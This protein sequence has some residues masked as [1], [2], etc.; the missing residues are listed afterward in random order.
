M[1]TALTKATNADRLY[2]ADNP[3]RSHFAKSL[4]EAFRAVWQVVESITLQVEESELLFGDETVYQ[5]ENRADSL[6]F[7]FWRSGIREVSFLEGFEDDGLMT[8]RKLLRQARSPGSGDFDLVSGLWESDFRLMQYKIVDLLGDVPIPE[9]GD[10]GLADL[11]TVASV[12]LSEADPFDNGEGRLDHGPT[13]VNWGDFNPTLYALDDAEINRL[14]VELK[15][16]V[17]RDLRGDVLSALFDRLEEDGPPGRGEEILEIIRSMLPHLLSRSRLDHVVNVLDELTNLLDTEGVLTDSET[18]LADS[19]LEEMG[20]PAALEELVRSLREGFVAPD[21]VV[22]GKLF[23][24]LR[25]EAIDTLL[26]L[27]RRSGE[28][29]RPLLRKGVNG[30]AERYPDEV[31]QLLHSD[32]PIIVTEATLVIGQLGLKRALPVVGELTEHQDPRVRLAT[33]RVIVQLEAVSLYHRLESMLRDEDVG[34]RIATVQAL[35]FLDYRP[36]VPWL[37]KSIASKAL[38]ETEL[39]EKMAFFRGYAALGGNDVVKPLTRHLA[40]GGRLLGNQRPDDMRACAAMA[41]G[42]IRSPESI[43]ALRSVAHDTSALVRNAAY[44][45]LKQAERPPGPA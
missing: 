35:Q 13:S 25:P 8:L 31:V 6:S 45:A 17:D 4:Q 33:L 40:A 16:E 30:I 43:E 27:A 32:D 41:L 29:L 36:A 18:Q 11:S 38:L 20:K 15:N 34:V 2:Q 37:A 14:R 24:R 9:V 10:I 26:R 42:E 22:L 1:I 5:E 23:Q 3:I 28:K 7:L 39:K 19:I 44:Q 12:A 21:V